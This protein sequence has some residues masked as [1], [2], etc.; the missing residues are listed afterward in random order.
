MTASIG[1]PDRWRWSGGLAAG[2]WFDGANTFMARAELGVTHDLFGPSIGLLSM[3]LEGLAGYRGSEPDLG[4]R[5]LLQ[6]GYLGGAVGVGSAS[7]P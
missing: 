7:S 5:A 2:G 4:A 3:G 1:Q 6:T